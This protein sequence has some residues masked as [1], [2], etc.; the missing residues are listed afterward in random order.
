LGGAWNVRGDGRT[1]VRAGGGLFYAPDLVQVP[2]FGALLDDSGQYINQIFKTPLDPAQSPP[3]LWASGAAI[4]KLPNTALS[5]TDLRSFGVKTG[6]GAPGRVIFQVDP[7][8]QNAYTIQGSV[9][10]AQQL[11]SDLAVEISYLSF[12]GRHLGLS[13][14]ANYRESGQVD[15]LLG[16]MYVAIDPTITERNVARS[17]GSSAY[18][19]MTVS[20]TKAYRRNYEFQVNYTWSRTEDDVTDT[21]SSLSAFMPTRLNRE[22]ATSAYDVPHTL[23]AHLIVQ[24]PKHFGGLRWTPVLHGRSGTPFTLLIGRDVNG[25]THA[26]DRPFLADRNTGRGPASWDLDMRISRDIALG[27]TGLKAELTAE[28]TNFANHTNFTSVNNII[29]TDPQYLSGPFILQG[30][31]GVSQFSPLG[32]NAAALARQVQFGLKLHF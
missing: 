27:E 10:V 31:R 16:P 1:V 7:A 19:G 29:G 30:R 32:F 25:D 15:P 12:Q 24:T 13:Q 2:Y 5:E 14:E 26:N 17:I 4:G 11:A 21:D 9:G 6:P 8:Y 28:A 22:W 3:V 23:V 20:L 18:R